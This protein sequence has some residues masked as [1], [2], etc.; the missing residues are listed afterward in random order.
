MSNTSMSRLLVVDDDVGTIHLLSRIL[1]D[2]G[3][4]FIATNGTDALA[5][6]RDQQ[7]DL[8]LLDA[9]MPTMDGFAVCKAIKDNP[10]FADL[11]ILFVTAH[12]DVDVETKAL[13]IGAVDFIS[14]PLS[15]PIVKA[16]VKTHLALKQRTDDLL[17]LASVDGLTG[18][19]NR[20]GFD[21]TLDM[22]W[23]RACRSKSPLSLLMIDVDYFKRFNDLY[24]HQA[25]DDCLRVVASALSATCHRPGDLVARYGGEEFATIL[26]ACDEVGASQFAEKLRASV[27]ARHI[28]HAASDVADE[29]TVSVGVAT[30]ILD[31]MTAGVE[32]PEWEGQCP[33]VRSCHNAAVNLIS[34]A[35]RALYEA[36]RAGRNRVACAG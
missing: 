31:C 9:E 27:A 21:A 28:S 29:V 26:P 18:L 5:M 24:G 35:D 2:L 10:A 20:R 25:G 19:A 16:R 14:K 22:E 32:H 8:V 4:V 34:A 17:R 30:L 7:P 33:A 23:R 3:E 12:T 13:E 15:P 36:K 11:P 6:V 1:M